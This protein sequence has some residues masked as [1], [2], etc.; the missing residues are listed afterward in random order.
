MKRGPRMDGAPARAGRRRWL[1]ILIV[2]LF[3]VTRLMLGHNGF[4]RPYL[5]NRIA[6]PLDDEQLADLAARDGRQIPVL[7]ARAQAGDASAMYF[8]GSMYDPD[9]NNFFYTP[10][11]PQKDAEVSIYWY[12]RAVAL[13]D[14]G[15]ERNLGIATYD[16]VGVPKD[17][18]EAARLFELAA[19]RNDDYGDYWLGFMLEHGQGEPADLPRAVALE[20]A[21]AAQNFAPAQRELGTMYFGGIGVAR[22]TAQAMH[23]WQLAAAQGDGPAKALLAR[24][25]AASAQ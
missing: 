7:L 22:N 9:P 3:S 19:A 25:G 10:S 20:Q 21:S 1:L 23:D 4:L 8:Y 16:G 5:Q 24:N 6:A 2:L 18:V 13:G 15:A 12:K 14:Q 17:E 11:I